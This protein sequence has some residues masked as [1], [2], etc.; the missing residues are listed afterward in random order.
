MKFLRALIMNRTFLQILNDIQAEKG[1]YF[2]SRQDINR[3]VRNKEAMINDV[4]K[5]YTRGLQS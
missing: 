5:G 4:G 1:V 2:Q 3:D